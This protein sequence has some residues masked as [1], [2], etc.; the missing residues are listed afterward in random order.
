MYDICIN[1]CYL[2]L[3]LLNDNHE[4]YAIRIMRACK[5]AKYMT[6]DLCD[7]VF[8]VEMLVSVYLYVCMYEN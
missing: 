2:S 6:N 7:N 5:G 1:V 8:R 3:F 4:T